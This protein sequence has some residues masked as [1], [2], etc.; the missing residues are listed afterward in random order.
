MGVVDDFGPEDGL[1][2]VAR[3]DGRASVGPAEAARDEELDAMALADAAEEV[4]RHD[5]GR[6]A[7][8]GAARRDR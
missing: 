6:A 8:V 7:H 5:L 2:D 1:G 4:V 3:L